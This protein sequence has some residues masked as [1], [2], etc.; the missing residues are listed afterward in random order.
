[1]RPADPV[2][3]T[4]DQAAV[5]ARLGDATVGIIGLG[6]LG[7]NAAMLLLRSGVRRFVLADPDV[8]E[9]SNL[10]RQLYF[11]DQ[12]GRLK[13][14]AL[15]E[16]LLRIEP[17]ALIDR[18]AVTVTPDSLAGLFGGVD[19]LLEA[20]DT[21]EDKAM[22]VETASDQLPDTPVV[23]VMGLAGCASA[24]AIT[25]ERVGENL[26]VV[27]DL[28]ADVRDGLP[29]VA[30]RVMVAAAHQAHMAT[31]ILLGMRDA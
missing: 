13:T 26:W 20:V 22:I 4:A 31:R 8:V 17:A 23:W 21:A 14:D 7:S 15:A 29:L 6:G 16:T 5:R 10:N 2:A 3:C 19:V 11:P 25:T 28:T 9:E 1:M 12:L 18:H 24:N 27:G 30:P